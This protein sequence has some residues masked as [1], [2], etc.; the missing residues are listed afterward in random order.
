LRAF[1][2]G[3]G[4]FGHAGRR[5]EAAADEA[6]NADGIAVECSH[7]GSRIEHARRRD[8]RPPGRSSGVEAAP[9]PA[10]EAASVAPS[11]AEGSLAFM[12]TTPAAGTPPVPWD[13]GSGRGPIDHVLR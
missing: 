5:V 11:A 7:A 4:Q 1:V 12:R 9:R 2:E 8:P 13:A 6:E 3:V 10:T